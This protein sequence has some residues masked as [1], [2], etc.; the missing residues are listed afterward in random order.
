M[1]NFNLWFIF[2]LIAIFAMTCAS[3]WNITHEDTAQ[4]NTL[5]TD[6]PTEHDTIKLAD[7]VSYTDRDGVMYF[8]TNKTKHLHGFTG[9]SIMFYYGY[10]FD[11]GE[12]NELR[13]ERKSLYR[14]TREVTTYF[15]S[16]YHK[17][18]F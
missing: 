2:S 8:D 16:L 3:Q 1:K 9:D 18:Y 5:Y 11:V 15:Y 13:F 14:Q 12:H 6:E 10:L 7:I 17:G 4:P